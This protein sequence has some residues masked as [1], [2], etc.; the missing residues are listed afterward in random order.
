MKGLTAEQKAIKKRIKD[1][2]LELVPVTG[3]TSPCWSHFYK[4]RDPEKDEYLEYIYAPDCET[5]YSFKSGG[6]STAK[7][8]WRNLLC[9]LGINFQNFTLENLGS[10]VVEPN[11]TEP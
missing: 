3:S 1:K 8:A 9:Q 2:E 4:I 10:Q 5:L 6:T 7:W 11:R